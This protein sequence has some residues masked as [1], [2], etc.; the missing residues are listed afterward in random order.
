M[1]PADK[2]GLEEIVKL[3]NKVGLEYVEAKKHAE[4][5]ELMKMPTRARIA[6]RIDDGKMNEAKLKRLTETDQEYITYITQLTE[7]KLI[8]EKLKVRYDSYKNLFEAR[9]SM[10]SYQKEEMKLL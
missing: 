10:M 5:L 4:Y 1:K 8:A 6:I 3:A 9:R 2:L 7:A